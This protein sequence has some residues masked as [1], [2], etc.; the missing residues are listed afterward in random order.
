MDVLSQIN[1]DFDNT[2]DKQKE[3][4]NLQLRNQCA[5]DVITRICVNAYANSK[6]MQVYDLYDLFVGDELATCTTAT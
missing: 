5:Y 2:I 1:S 3:D 4:S 6:F